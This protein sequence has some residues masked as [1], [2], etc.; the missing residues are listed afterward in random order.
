MDFSR[1]A[2]KQKPVSWI[3]PE[4]KPY[5]WDYWRIKMYL[6]ENKE[7]FSEDKQFLEDFLNKL[8][9]EIGY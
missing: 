9:E 3:E 2:I 1:F 5:K 8:H 4:L 6:Y 7:S